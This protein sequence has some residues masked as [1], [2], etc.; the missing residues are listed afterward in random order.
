MSAIAGGAPLAPKSA[1]PMASTLGAALPFRR[2]SV[3]RR[4]VRE[5][6]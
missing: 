1:L 5:G 6:A 3:S 4:T 2:W